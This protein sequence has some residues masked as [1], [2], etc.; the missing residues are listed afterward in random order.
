MDVKS[1]HIARCFKKV[2]GFTVGEFTR[3][4][5]IKEAC[6]LLL[7]TDLPL[8][9]VALETGFYDQAHLNNVFKREI[10]TTPLNFRKKSRA[11]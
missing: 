2:T 10:R 9:E 6:G 1:F 3:R 5:R 8:A 4:A 11:R 7:D